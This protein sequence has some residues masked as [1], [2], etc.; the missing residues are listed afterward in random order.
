MFRLSIVSPERILFEDQVQSL[1]VPG[2]EGYLGVLSKHAPLISTLKVGEITFRNKAN[3]QIIM[4]TSGGFI[5]VSDNVATILAET[6]EFVE[7][8]DLSRAE[9]ELKK[10]EE[11]LNLPITP[12]ERELALHSRNKARNRIAIV[13]KYK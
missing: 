4:A 13:K 6:A 7:E 12:P 9:T 3:D 8:I 10:A 2:G 11:A 1:I 5:E